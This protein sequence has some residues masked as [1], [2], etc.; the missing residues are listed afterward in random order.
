MSFSQTEC[1]LIIGLVAI[2]L[3]GGGMVAGFIWRRKHLAYYRDRI[4]AAEMLRES[5]ERYRA[6]FENS[7]DAVLLTIPD[8]RILAA[9][10]SACRMFGLTEE[11]ICRRG[12]EGVVDVTDPRL[13]AALEERARTGRFRGELTC[14]RGDG[15]R[16]AGEVSTAVFRD[17]RGQERTS[18]I[19]RDITER[20][21][22]EEA[23]RRSVENFRRSLDESPLGVRIVS[24]T[25]ETL[26]ANGALL[27]IYGYDSV[28][29]FKRTPVEN[30]YTP[31]SYLEFQARRERRRRGI[32]DPSE[33]FVSIIRKDG[34]VRHLEVHRKEILWDDAKQY[35]VLYIDITERKEAES[36]LKERDIRFSK[37]AARVPGMIYQFKRKP[38]G[39]YCVPFTSEGIRNIFGC[40]PEDVRDDFAPIARVILPEDLKMVVG[41]IE[42]SAANLAIWRCEYRVQVPGKPVRWMRGESTPERQ[43]D[44][45]IIWHG[46]NTD[47]TE[48]KLLEEES[49]RFKVQL[50]DLAERIHRIREESQIAI[51]REIHDEIGGGLTGVKMSLSWVLHKMRD[52]T[53]V[54]NHDDLFQRIDA[55]GRLIDNLIHNVRRIGTELRPAVL[56]DL[57]LIAALEWECAEF[58]KRTGISCEFVPVFDYVKLEDPTATAVFRIFQEAL[59]NVARH[60]GADRVTVLFREEGGYYF[61]DVMDNGRGI[62]ENEILGMKSLGILG[63]KERSL[64]LGGELSISGEPGKGTT[65]VLKIPNPHR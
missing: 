20:R 58:S 63:M 16:F 49:E 33:Y 24:E 35:Q 56:D 28:D 5:E 30:R 54:E 29:E 10:L 26:Y 25:G 22:V 27:E 52:E 9:N 57:G 40:S 60:S 51:A 48:S 3:I 1:F 8:G 53:S 23:I 65:V 55:A 47:V 21:N 17:H 42:N 39:T 32:D 34:K 44:G 2:L 37:L 11:E 61:L 50:R 12:R 13:S 18:I 4:E 15:T 6:L 46:F 62:R 45:S 36:E 14:I 59:T 64:V 19:I 38:D 31:Q 41:S 43:E 7:L